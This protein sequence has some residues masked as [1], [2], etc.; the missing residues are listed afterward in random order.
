MCENKYKVK[1]HKWRKEKNFSVISNDR[2]ELFFLDDISSD[3]YVLFQVARSVEEVAEIL[4]NEYLYDIE[5][6]EL[7]NDIEVLLTQLISVGLMEVSL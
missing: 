1:Y 5:I 2:L 6:E 7:I 3:I 4:I